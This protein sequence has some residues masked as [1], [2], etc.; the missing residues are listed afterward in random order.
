[1]YMKAL[2]FM[3]LVVGLIVYF[4]DIRFLNKIK[5]ELLYLLLMIPFPER[6]IESLGLGLKEISLRS[7]FVLL[8]PFLDLGLHQDYIT[9]SGEPVLRYG[10]P[11]S[12]L[13]S[14]L[15]FFAFSLLFAY[16]YEKKPWRAIVLIASSPFVAVLFNS[17]R[18]SLLISMATANADIALSFFHLTSGPLLVVIYGI[19]LILIYRRSI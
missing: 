5:F 9:V 19:L 13:E 7:A 11:C 14:F 1:M 17:L 6:I 15:A 3:I 10:L 12:G 16:L 4:F 18:L 8:S 2:S